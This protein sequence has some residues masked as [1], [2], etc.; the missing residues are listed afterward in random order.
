MTRQTSIETYRA[1]EAEGLLS[2]LRFKVYQMVFKHGPMTGNQI[3]ELAPHKNS[4]AYTTRLSELR[5]LGCVYEV[6]VAP[7]PVTGRNV[8]WWDVTAN[9]PR[10]IKTLKKP[11]DNPARE[12]LREVQSTVSSAF[13][14]APLAK[15]IE[16]FLKGEKI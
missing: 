15:K 12:L 7:C 16:R 8:I 11:K 3:I 9:L 2:E 4:G 1:I 14:G 5:E 6:K 10:E 13:L